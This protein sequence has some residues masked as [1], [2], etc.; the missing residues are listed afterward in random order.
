MPLLR[1]LLLL[2]PKSHRRRWGAEIELT[3][4]LDSERARGSGPWRHARFLAR[5]TLDLAV[6]ALLVRC[7]RAARTAPGR[8]HPRG[9]PA[10]RPET[11][12]HRLDL[13]LLELRQTLRRLRAA[14]LFTA[15]ALLTLALGIGAN[16]AIFSIVD[17]VLLRPIGLSEE[18]RLVVLPRP[19]TREADVSMPDAVDLRAASETLDELALISPFWALDLTGEGDPER[20]LASAVESRWFGILGLPPVAGRLLVAADDRPGAEPVIVLGAA[21]WR[22][23]FGADPDLVGRTLVLSDV[24]H[25]V[26]GVAPPEADLFE[27]GAQAFVSIGAAMPWALEQRGTNNFETLARLAPGATLEQARLEIRALTERLAVEHP[28]TNRSKVLDV[29]PLRTFLVG[30]LRPVLVVLLAGVG[31][32]LL[33]VCAN[34]ANLL[35]VRA[36]ARRHEIAT[37]MAMGGGRAAVLRLLLAESGVLALAGAALGVG[38]AALGTRAALAIAPASLPRAAA[39][40]IDQRV[41]LFTLAIGLFSTVVAG[42]VP[43][44]DT[45]RRDLVGALGR[46]AGA[47]EAAR[48]GARLQGGLVVLEVAMA[49]VL[50]TFGALLLRSFRELRATDLGFSPAG[51]LTANVVLPESRYSEPAAQTAAVRGILEALDARPE[52]NGAGF[53]IGA[54][55]AGF[56]AIGATIA[57]DERPLDQQGDQPSARIRPIHGDYFG[58]LGIAV[59]HGR[60]LDAHDRE[61]SLPVAVVN[62]AFVSTHWP[63]TADRPQAVLGKRVAIVGW[64]ERPTWYEVVGV[65]A[66]VES[67]GLAAGDADALYIPYAQRPNAWARFGTLAVRGA[68]APERLGRA[69]QEAVWS[70]DPAVPLESVAPLQDLVDR[71][72]A[73]ER[74]VSTLLGAFALFAL[75]IALQGLYGVL[76]YAVVSRRREIG[77]RMALGA[78]SA[79]V[80]RGMLQRGLAMAAGGLAVGALAA[81]AASRLLAGLLHGVSGADPATYGIAAAVVTLATLLAAALPARRALRVDPA[82]TLREG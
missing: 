72:S 32:V 19:G 30:E 35:V 80:L 47:S 7:S 58:A 9:G 73:R 81:L 36:T 6:S 40:S 3:L 45:T 82:A 59:R 51:V 74:F 29:V 55:L 71:A 44:L 27:V 25:T 14:P 42:L 37:R 54:P 68:V 26:V 78:S 1:L 61:G 31:L 24:P 75:A 23:R 4:E 76:A 10:R 22:E 65:V 11:P 64:S 38:V 33:V 16:T 77:V 57:L 79:A 15:A 63:Q 5:A 70:V 56:G 28:E 49:F 21:F 13:L 34:V 46:G 12:M 53:V 66:D 50:L 2:L 41:L 62:E 17:G 20:V 48:R 67:N 18:Q 43:W 60:G 52:I 39:V 8:R 69:L